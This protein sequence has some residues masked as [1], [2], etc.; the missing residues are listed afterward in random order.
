MA[1][2]FNEVIDILDKWQFFYGQR[3]GRELWMDK[4]TEIQE[5]GIA[6]FNRDLET[7][8]SFINML[9]AGGVPRRTCDNCRHLT[10]INNGRIYAKC[11][12]TGFTFLP[13]ETDTREYFCAFYDGN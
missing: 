1:A 9:R 2:T 11:E 8:R 4:P 12:K 3:A 6:N 10:V 13:F 7:V 5:E